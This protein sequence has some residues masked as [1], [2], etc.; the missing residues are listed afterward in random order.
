MLDYVS[1]LLGEMAVYPLSVVIRNLQTNSPLSQQSQGSFVQT[2][3]S[4]WKTEGIRGFY[5]GFLCHTWNALSVYFITMIFFALS[6]SVFNRITYK[7]KN[8][9]KNKEEEGDK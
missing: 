6:R 1:G 7:K 3:K 5:K 2:V 4:L 8:E 9:E